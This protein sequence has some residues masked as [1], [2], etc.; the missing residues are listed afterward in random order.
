MIMFQ[1][2]QILHPTDHISESHNEH[3][4]DDQDNLH[5]KT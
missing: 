3:L 1:I 2:L 4:A 5:D